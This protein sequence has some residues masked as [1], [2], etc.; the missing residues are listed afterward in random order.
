LTQI[1][2]AAALSP[3][4]EDNRDSP[5]YSQPSFLPTRREKETLD[6]RIFLEN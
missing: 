3:K 2:N 1:K 6:R 5:A 4:W